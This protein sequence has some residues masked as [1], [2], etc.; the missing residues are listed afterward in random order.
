[1]LTKRDIQILKVTF[2]DPIS[3]RFNLID[4]KFRQIDER[5]NL[6]EETLKNHNRR[7]LVVQDVVVGINKYIE[8]EL[9][10]TLHSLEQ[11]QK[12]FEESQMRLEESNKELKRSD[13]DT[14]ETLKAQQIRI[15]HLEEKVSIF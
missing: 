3:N 10:I 13:R 9:T 5:F 8:G 7:I 4:A 1:M 11:G 12:K 14:N 6:I 2:F 15:T